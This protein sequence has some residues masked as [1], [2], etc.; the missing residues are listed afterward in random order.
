MVSKQSATD[1]HIEVFDG[2]PPEFNYFKS[3]IEKTR[4]SRA[5]D[6]KNRLTQLI[7]YTSG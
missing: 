3:I 2:N 4:E 1:I 6:P 7:K 5:A